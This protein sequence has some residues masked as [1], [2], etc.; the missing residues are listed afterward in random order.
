MLSNYPA[1]FITFPDL[2]VLMPFALCF[3]DLEFPA[4]PLL[5]LFFCVTD[6]TVLTLAVYK[7]KRKFHCYYIGLLCHAFGLQPTNTR[8]LYRHK[9]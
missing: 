1:F 4:G 8:E 6:L 5:D 3:V 9:R 2:P 7:S